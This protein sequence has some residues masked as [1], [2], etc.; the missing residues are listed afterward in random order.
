MH[1]NRLAAN[2][3]QREATH[4]RARAPAASAAVTSSNPSPR[5]SACER[6]IWVSCARLTG[7]RQVLPSGVVVLTLHCTSESAVK[8]NELSTY[9]RPTHMQLDPEGETEF[10][11]A[12]SFCPGGD[13]TQDEII[14]RGPSANSPGTAHILCMRLCVQVPAPPDST[15]DGRVVLCCL[16]PL[17]VCLSPVYKEANA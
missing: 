7:W 1:A 12:R 11:A 14:P 6:Q 16:S 13:C 17:C 8:H 9:A 3:S 5:V 15:K 4:T 2:P 10:S